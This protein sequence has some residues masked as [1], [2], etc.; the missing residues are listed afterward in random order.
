MELRIQIPNSLM[1]HWRRQD[2][3]WD[4]YENVYE[5]FFE[6]HPEEFDGI[7]HEAWEYES[8]HRK[9]FKPRKYN[10]SF[11]LY[12]QGSY[13]YF[14]CGVTNWAKFLKARGLEDE[15]PTVLRYHQHGQGEALVFKAARHSHNSCTFYVDVSD[16]DISWHWN[17]MDESLVELMDE[18]L[19]EEIDRL[20]DIVQ[21]EIEELF[22]RLQ[23]ELEDACDEISS[24]EYIRDA[25]YAN[26]DDDEIFAWC[27]E[28]D[29]GVVWKS[30]PC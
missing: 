23:S 7:W 21:G 8:P 4:W 2:F 19:S 27:L 22:G 29:D 30:A 26:W 20:E 3:E 14:P 17:G 16:T 5:M 1:E 25:I 13:V 12:T 24:D 28:H 9:V 18:W 11:Q 10:V 6:D 15:F